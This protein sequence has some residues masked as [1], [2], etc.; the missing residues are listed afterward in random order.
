MQE[1][2]EADGTEKHGQGFQ[3]P[4]SSTNGIAER[5]RLYCA[6]ME[7][8][9][10]TPH[11]SENDVKANKDIAALSYLYVV[12]IFVFLLKGKDSE[13]IRFH[14]KQ[15]MILF[16]V[17]VIAFFL[18]FPFGVIA[19]L[20]VFLGCVT[21]FIMAAHGRWWEIPFV[22]GMARGELNQRRSWKQTVDI[23]A[24]AT[25]H[26]AEKHPE[27]GKTPEAPTD[28]SNPPPTVP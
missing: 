8:A 26:I 3:H 24:S 23:I 7:A 2:L 16:G 5:L 28:H 11:T 25:S 15:A 9:P 27:N 10:T 21:G 4:N 19:Q 18:P 20:L 1:T 6:R 12:S 22:G 17:C 13:F 14:S